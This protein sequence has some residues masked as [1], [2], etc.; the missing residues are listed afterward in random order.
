MNARSEQSIADV[1]RSNTL[2]LLYQSIFTGIVRL[3]AKRQH[4]SDPVTF[5]RRIRNALEDVEREAKIAGYS[6]KETRDAEAA[7]VA[8]LDETILSL[9]GPARDTWAEKPL[10]VELYGQATA[11][12][13]F[14]E[15]LEDLQ[16]D[17]DSA[18]LA[19]VLEVYLLCLLLG[20][21]GRY[22]GQLRPHLR[23]IAD[24]VRA[25][26]EGIRGALY[27]LSPPLRFLNAAEPAAAPP[28]N[29]RRWFLQIGAAMAAAIG[30][31]L[32]AKIILL[33]RLGNLET[34][35]SQLK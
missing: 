32:I 27:Q 21:E 11:G 17:S 13:V 28:P 1:S 23:G 34:M 10:S 20:F 4:L 25:Q 29:D 5:R 12:E 19:D 24:R 15:H 22:S 9:T 14:F 16:N 31:F 7:A 26:V 33:W 6:V 30:V 8:F 2:A 3:Q 18:H 35:L